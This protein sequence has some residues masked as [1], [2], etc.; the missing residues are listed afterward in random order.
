MSDRQRNGF[1]LVLV[2]GL[3]LASLV[4][5]IGIPGAVKHKKTQLGL[6]LKGGVQL[7]YQGKPTAQSQVTPAALNR[8]VD[9]M[10]K[11]VDSL[12]VSEPEISTEGN[13]LISVGLP[14]VQNTKRAEQLVGTTARLEFYDWEANALLPNGKPAAKELQTQDQNPLAVSQGSSGA[15]PGS[16]GA[17]SMP[18]LKAVQ[19]ASKQTPWPSPHNA[20]AGA[21]YFM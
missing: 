4:V 10:R 21:E 9:V 12:G 8:A 7:V 19:L 1:I 14:D 17:G 13:N 3:I 15:S 20:R 6:D 18:L 5:I 2:V 16:P 11:R